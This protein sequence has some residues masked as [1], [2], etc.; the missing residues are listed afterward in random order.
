MV[1]RMSISKLECETVRLEACGSPHLRPGK[2]LM[3]YKVR[4]MPYP[5]HFY[6]FH[7]MVKN[8]LTFMSILLQLQGK[9]CGRE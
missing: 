2:S 3:P 9:R 7:A 4:E 6:F 8:K 1:R 5:I